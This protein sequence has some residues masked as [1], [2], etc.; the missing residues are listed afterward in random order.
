[1]SGSSLR[2]P[3]SSQ[4]ST[5]SSTGA[6]LADI[7]EQLRRKADTNSEAVF[8]AIVL[9][10]PNGAH[11]KVTVDNAGALHTVAF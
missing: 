7:T 11:F 5:T 8:A 6:Q 3:P 10:A 2:F 1:M 9:R 4:V